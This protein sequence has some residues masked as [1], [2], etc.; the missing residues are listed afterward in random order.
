MTQNYTRILEDILKTLNSQ[1]A[2]NINCEIIVSL[3]SE[4]QKDFPALQKK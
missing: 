2:N 1:L 3:V 4:K